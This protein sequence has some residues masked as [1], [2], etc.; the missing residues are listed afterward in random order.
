[1]PV[2]PWTFKYQSVENTVNGKKGLRSLENDT[3]DLASEVIFIA[4]NK[5]KIASAKEGDA[6]ITFTHPEIYENGKEVPFTMYTTDLSQYI[7][8]DSTINLSDWYNCTRALCSITIPE[9]S[10]FDKYGNPNAEFISNKNFITP[11]N[12]TLDG[13]AGTYEISGNGEDYKYNTGVLPPGFDND[14][15]ISKLSKEVS[16]GGLMCNIE[17]KN[18]LHTGSVLKAV[19]YEEIGMIYIPARQNIAQDEVTI[20]GFND[21]KP[22]DGNIV[23]ETPDHAPA[24]MYVWNDTDNGDAITITSYPG[25]NQ[26]CM[27]S[28]I[29][30]LAVYDGQELV[31][32]PWYKVTYT[33]MTKANN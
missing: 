25:I 7:T 32:N 16:Y 22:F 8:T 29:W 6:I 9:G 20:E 18:L 5:V 3:L 14:V 33:Y 4:A 10:F 17:I 31:V 1:M 15:T 2:K 13:I 28:G 24:V 23:F 11:F 19:F 12:Y 26:N 21:D 27:Y 30:N